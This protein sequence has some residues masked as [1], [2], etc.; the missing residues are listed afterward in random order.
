MDISFYL[1]DSE[2]YDEPNMVFNLLLEDLYLSLIL[3]THVWSI[4]VQ[5]KIV[6]YIYKSTKLLF[7][8][9]SLRVD[10]RNR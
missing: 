4:L 6:L 3:T 8:K 2:K 10:A 5:T 9:I 7:K 1:K